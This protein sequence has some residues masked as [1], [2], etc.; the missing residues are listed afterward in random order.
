[1]LEHISILHELN[2]LSI[3]LRI[4]L[5]ALLG[6]IVGFERELRRSPAGLRTFSLVC[7]AA[8]LSMLLNE[9]LVNTYG[10]GDMARLGAAVLSGIGFLGAGTIM[11]TRNQQIKGLTT[12]AEL[13]AIAGVGLALGSGFYSAALI[14]TLT[15]LITV[16]VLQRVDTRLMRTNRSMTIYLELSATESPYRL[17]QRPEL[18][19]ISVSSCTRQQIPPVTDGDSTYLVELSL[20]EK[21]YHDDVITQ[22]HTVPDVHYL[23]EVPK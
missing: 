16:A 2:L 13:W 10:T 6:G 23:C 15:I 8:S 20:L 4:I 5:A 17:F 14:A 21:R 12:A 7:V 1:M 18:D 22:L 3:T 19:G 11:T 9:Y